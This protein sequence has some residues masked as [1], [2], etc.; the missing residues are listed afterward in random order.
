LTVLLGLI[1]KELLALSRDVH[2][3][4][5]LF[6][7]PV[8]FVIVM[9]LALRN[10]YEPPLRA[11]RHAIDV[12]DKGPFA[13]E[14]GKLWAPGHGPA[15]AL[16]PDWEAQLRA[17]KLKYVIVLDEGLSKELAVL[18]SPGEARLHLLAE[19]GIDGNLFNALR[20]ELQAVGGQLKARGALQTLG[21]NISPTSTNTQKLV[22]AERYA[23]GGPRP[24]SVQQNV[25]AWL[26]FGM[27]FVIAALSNLF[28]EE[29]RCG[30]L[31]RLRSLGV[32]PFVLLVSK[33]LPY[34]A[35][36][37]V[38]AVLMLMV[39]AWLMP[40]LGGDALSFAQVNWPAL[41]LVVC[42]I[43]AAAVSLALMLSCLVRTQAQASAV[44]PVLNV[45]MA[46]LGGIMV[47]TFVMPAAMQTIAR[48]SPM[49]WGLE[50]LLTVLLRGGGVASAAPMML[51]LLGFAAVMLL[52]AWLLFK[53]NPR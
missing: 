16:P 26:V 22:S 41:V 48:L 3:L 18:G 10:V 6:A 43:G 27:F 53:R 47:P 24:S 14:V 39:G 50:A 25:S 7:M 44:G 29:R 35:V 17:G 21:E 9:S 51:R 38:Q 30:A 34:F 52:A 8:L 32:P 13:A 4:A 12:R 36:N 2:G 23:S 15:E 49:N 11:L 28:V 42:A 20:A 46:A 33:A 40:L 45:L 5:A 31:A 37:L 19:P 1:K